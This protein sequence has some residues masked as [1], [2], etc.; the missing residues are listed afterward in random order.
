M[1][2]ICICNDKYNQKL[3][4]LRNHC[5]EL[6]YRFG[7]ATRA[8]LPLCGRAQQAR[9]FVSACA[10]ALSANCFYDYPRLLRGPALCFNLLLDTWHEGL[11]R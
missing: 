9:H 5:L 8:Q 6:D 7:P 4:S 1:P 3:K 10:P 11:W 2:I